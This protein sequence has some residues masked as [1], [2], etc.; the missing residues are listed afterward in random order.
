[1]P[2]VT[3]QV[4]ARFP[5]HELA[6][7][8]L[9]RRSES[10]REMCEEY[11]DGIEALERWQRAALPKASLDELGGLLADL[12]AEILAALEQDARAGLGPRGRTGGL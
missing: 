1:M 2:G 12:E 3:R 10:F 11:A 7:E 6:I 5:A 9:A 4:I 8:R